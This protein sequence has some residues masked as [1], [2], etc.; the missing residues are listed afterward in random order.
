[1]G[2]TLKSVTVLPGVASTSDFTPQSTQHYTYADKVR[3]I[4]GFPEKIG[5]WQSLIV[6][7]PYYMNG[8]CRALYSYTL[9]NVIYYLIGTHTNLYQIQGN[10]VFNATP[11]VDTANTYNNILGTYYGTLSADPFSVVAGIPSVTVL[12]TGHPF[13]NGDSITFSGATSFAGIS[14]SE[15]N[16][17]V[18]IGNVTTNTYTFTISSVPNSMTN[19]G[20]GSV[21][22]ASRIV[23]VLEPNTDY[24][25]GD[26]IVVD[27]VASTV[28][29]IPPADI[30]GIRIVRGVNISGYNIVASGVATSSASNAGGNVSI[31]GEIPSGQLN[32]TTGSGYG[33]GL[34]GTGYYG[35]SKISTTPTSPTIWSFDRFGDLIVMTQGNQTGLYSWDSSTNT[36][37][38]L[39]ANAPTALNYTFVT[40]NIAVTLGANGVTNRIKWSDQGNLTTW[41]ATAQNQAGEDDIEGAGQFISHAALRGWNLLFTQTSVY[42]FR[43]INKP[44]VFETKLLDP[45]R[46]L[47]GQ[48][49]RIVV[50]GIAYWMGIDNFYMYRGANVEVIPSNSTTSSTIK[51]YVFNSINLGQIN[52]A[53]CWYNSQFNEIW[54]HYPSKSATECDRIARYNVLDGTW[55]M[56]TLN[57]TAGEYPTPLTL[58]PYLSRYTRYS[59]GAFDDGFDDGFSDGTNSGTQTLIYQHEKGSDDDGSPLPFLLSTPMFSTGSSNTVLLGGVYQDNTLSNGPLDWTITTKLY[60]NQVP[61]SVTYTIPYDSQNLIYRRRGRYWQYDIAG[62]TLG[63]RW[64]AG[65]WQEKY[66]KSG[67]R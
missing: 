15:L 57:R 53:F 61:D 37:P 55:V 33:V 30:T 39:V 26:N 60:P 20:G 67:T 59:V 46:G 10:N 21:V 63:Q 49:A 52:K 28:G 24:T 6:S 1:M 3:F 19:G 50:N 44:Y 51:N 5:G 7:T 64:R 36:L 42:T 2:Y 34:Y 11:V 45:S 65:V 16:T 13:L 66:E 48:N 4:D 8:C 43:Y 25:D 47:I 41:T 29:G 56:D 12:D 9:R 23:S 27:S 22:R 38:A 35:V 40:D 54:F 14:A 62:N 58:T 18:T 32:S 17:T 31:R